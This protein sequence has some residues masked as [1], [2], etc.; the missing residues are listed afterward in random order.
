VAEEDEL[1]VLDGHRRI[2]TMAVHHRLLDGATGLL[3]ALDVRISKV[4]AWGFVFVLL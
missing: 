4:A 1:P 3:D 2:C